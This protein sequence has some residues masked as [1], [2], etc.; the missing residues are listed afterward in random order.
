MSDN[1]L[2]ALVGR[3]EKSRAATAA[4]AAAACRNAPTFHVVTIT[5]SYITGG[6]GGVLIRL[7]YLLIDSYPEIFTSDCTRS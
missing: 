3:T 5:V 7:A 1:F 6:R 2:A 4:A